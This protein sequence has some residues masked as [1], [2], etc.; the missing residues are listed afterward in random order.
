MDFLLTYSANIKHVRSLRQREFRLLLL[1]S[2]IC[3]SLYH[4][5]SYDCSLCIC[6]TD[7][8]SHWA[9]TTC[10]SSNRVQEVDVFLRAVNLLYHLILVKWFCCFGCMAYSLLHCIVNW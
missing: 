8:N 2:I 1:L 4:W 3:E 9:L 5:W 10:I 7:V 6:T